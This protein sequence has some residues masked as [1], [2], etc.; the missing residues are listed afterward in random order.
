MGIATPNRRKRSNENENSTLA[1]AFPSFPVS[2]DACA[3]VATSATL[4]STAH[5]IFF[6]RPPLPVKATRNN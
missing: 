6:S 5:D 3:L 2:G 4:D 1:V